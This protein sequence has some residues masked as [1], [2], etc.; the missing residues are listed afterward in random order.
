M[1]K[2]MA[3]HYFGMKVYILY[4]H[5]CVHMFTHTHTHI[6]IIHLKQMS[7]FYNYNNVISS[8]LHTKFFIYV[9]KINKI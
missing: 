4:K 7:R 3:Y 2:Q 6:H 5:A 9:V 1:F 8:T